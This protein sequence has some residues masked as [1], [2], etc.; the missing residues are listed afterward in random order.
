LVCS[1]LGPNK[2]VGLYARRFEKAVALQGFGGIAALAVT[3]SIIAS[4]TLLP[5]FAKV[6]LPRFLDLE[7]GSRPMQVTVV[8]AGA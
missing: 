6:F 8:T 1:I 2:P 3:T 7:T 5:A 4:P